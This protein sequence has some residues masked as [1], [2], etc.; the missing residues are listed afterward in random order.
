MHRASRL[1]RLTV[2]PINRDERGCLLQPERAGEPRPQFNFASSGVFSVLAEAEILGAFGL[3]L[4]EY[5]V[6]SDFPILIKP[7]GCCAQTQG[8]C[9]AIL[10]RLIRDP[11]AT[12]TTEVAS[13]VDKAHLIIH[14]VR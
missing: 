7:D 8:P 14:N 4:A 12:V 9:Y 13:S 1:L 6:Q 5:Q 3:E 2:E 10:V 11:M